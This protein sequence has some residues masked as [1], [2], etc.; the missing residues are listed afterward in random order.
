MAS[1]FKAKLFDSV[2]PEVNI[3]SLE[4][5]LIKSAIFFQAYSTAF[6]ASQP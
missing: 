6:S 1:P 4:S 2:A 3:I 5:A